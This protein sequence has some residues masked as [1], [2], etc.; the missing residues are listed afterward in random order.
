MYFETLTYDQEKYYK[1]NKKV[2]LKEAVKNQYKR[3]GILLGAIPS[4]AMYVLRGQTVWCCFK[5]KR[6][7]RFKEGHRVPFSLDKKPRSCCVNKYSNKRCITLDW[8]K[9]FPCFERV[10]V[11]ED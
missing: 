5:R 9:F 4:T 10:E 8:G 7:I 3:V 11:D 6:P 2:I 1:D